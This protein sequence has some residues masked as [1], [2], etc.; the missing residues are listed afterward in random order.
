M[1]DFLEIFSEIDL[2]RS[3]PEVFQELRDSLER[4]LSP[5]W[6]ALLHKNPWNGSACVEPA[7]SSPSL[8]SL[9]SKQRVDGAPP[10][11]DDGAAERP[12]PIEGAAAEAAGA[13]AAIVGAS[14]HETIRFLE[15][16][17]TVQVYGGPILQRERYF[18]Y[19]AMGNKKE[20]QSSERSVLIG[21]KALLAHF[22][23]VSEVVAYERT[24]S[25]A[26]DAIRVP[27]MLTDS[28][29]R[30]L[31]INNALREFFGHSASAEATG[32]N[33]RA[34][35]LFH[36]EETL[37]QLLRKEYLARPVVAISPGSEEQISGVLHSMAG[38]RVPHGPRLRYIYFLPDAPGFSVESE[39]KKRQR[40]YPRL[41][42]PQTLSL[43][44][45]EI[46]VAIRIAAGETSKEIARRLNVSIRTV[47]FHRQ[48]L[49]D[50]LGIVG[51]GLSLRHALLEY[52][53][54]RP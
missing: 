39:E 35:F 7:F 29:G 8:V 3:P 24:R 38:K 31:E 32:E 49:R 44:A 22:Y 9:L 52:E 48:S 28:S 54:P 40:R 5:S 19:F 21:F 12:L 25:V 2:T 4:R 41:A 13:F 16:N 27:G 20:L 1:D 47:Q 33:L 15:E 18:G 17:G 43:T 10:P 26:F 30:I 37:P 11:P 53:R 23:R 34:L 50:K 46:D 51:R 14:A 36:T 45:R 6:V 42:L